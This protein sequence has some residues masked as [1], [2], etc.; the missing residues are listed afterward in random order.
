[1]WV[2]I[3]GWTITKKKNIHAKTVN[4]A[5]SAATAAVT[6]VLVRAAKRK[7]SAGKRTTCSAGSLKRNNPV[8]RMKSRPIKQDGM[9]AG[10]NR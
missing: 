7:K 8:P 4:S 5:S 3:N 9:N 1:M 10:L 2:I 6:C